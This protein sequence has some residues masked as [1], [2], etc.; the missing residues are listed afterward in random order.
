MKKIIRIFTLVTA[1]LT[2][3]N[4]S[5]EK[6]GNYANA[7]PFAY[8]ET[9]TGNSISFSKTDF[10]YENIQD[11]RLIPSGN[12]LGIKFF[13]SGVLVVGMTDINTSNGKTNPSY[14]AGIRI[15]DIPR[16]NQSAIRCW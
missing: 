15:N 11:I 12:T 3:I 1:F 4:F 14:D 16:P 9:Q 13:T 7:F 8:K 10:S 6:S 5:F 2:V